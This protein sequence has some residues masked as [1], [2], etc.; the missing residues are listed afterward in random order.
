MKKFQISLLAFVGFFSFSAMAAGCFGSINDTMDFLQLNMEKEEL[1]D[2]AQRAEEELRLGDIVASLDQKAFRIGEDLSG[3]CCA[4]GQKMAPRTASS[5]SIKQE[6]A[7][8]ARLML[9]AAFET[10]PVESRRETI[11]FVG[12]LDRQLVEDCQ[13]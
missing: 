9:L 10:M 3:E 1:R 8:K 12:A 5:Y 7:A 6:M 13:I 11:S 2:L 4:D